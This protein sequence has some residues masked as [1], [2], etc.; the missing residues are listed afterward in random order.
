MQ[1]DKEQ[2]SALLDQLKS[3]DVY[4]FDPL[5]DV[6]LLSNL[7]NEFPN[8]DFNEELHRLQLWLSDLAPGHRIHHRLLLRKWIYNASKKATPTLTPAITKR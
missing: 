4:P 5:K 1:T 8:V 3:I 2:L 6:P 7:I